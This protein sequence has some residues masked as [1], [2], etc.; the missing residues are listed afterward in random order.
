MA[1]GCWT[2]EYRAEGPSLRSSG[3]LLATSG[4]MLLQRLQALLQEYG[5]VQVLACWH[6]DTADLGDSEV[7]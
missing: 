1:T 6:S 4:T 2:I 5:T 7:F 3:E